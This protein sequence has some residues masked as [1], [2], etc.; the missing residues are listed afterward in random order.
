MRKSS[1][2]KD[3][4]DSGKLLT[5]PSPATRELLHLQAAD[6]FLPGPADRFLLFPG[7]RFQ[8][9]TLAR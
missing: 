6:R 1:K 4:F 8:P 9:N 5:E 7:E 2:F 3:S